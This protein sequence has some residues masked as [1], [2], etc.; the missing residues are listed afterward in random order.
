MEL[1]AD[2]AKQLNADAAKQRIRSK[3]LQTALSA[4]VKDYVEDILDYVEGISR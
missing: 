4:A 2:A 1:N 3:K